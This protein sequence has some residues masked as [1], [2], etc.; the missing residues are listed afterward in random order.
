ME[1]TPVIYTNNEVAAMNNPTYMGPDLLDSNDGS[2]ASNLH[3][4]PRSIYSDNIAGD[5]DYMTVPNQK[6]VEVS[7]NSLADSAE[8]LI[9]EEPPRYSTLQYS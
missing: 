7:L 9:K 4:D 6:T 8:D 5:G 1:M 3:F 2:V